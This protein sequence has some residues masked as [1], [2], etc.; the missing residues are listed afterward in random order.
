[1][2]SKF[3]AKHEKRKTPNWAQLYASTKTLL[4]S[5]KHCSFPPKANFGITEPVNQAD[6]PKGETG[7]PI[8][9]YKSEPAKR[10]D[11][12]EGVSV[13]GYWSDCFCLSNSNGVTTDYQTNYIHLRPTILDPKSFFYNSIGDL[14]IIRSNTLYFLHCIAERILTFAFVVKTIKNSN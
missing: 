5:P 4:I 3:W 9:G 2:D 14:S 6:K 1:M 10:V 7:V 13:V 8:V 11:T 12:Y